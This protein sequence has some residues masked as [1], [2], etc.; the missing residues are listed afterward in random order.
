MLYQMLCVRNKSSNIS[1]CVCSLPKHRHKRWPERRIKWA[2]V[3]TYTQKR[4]GEISAGGCWI[5]NP[6]CRIAYS[7]KS[8]IVENYITNI[9]GSLHK[10]SCFACAKARQSASPPAQPL[11]QPYQHHHHHHCH[12]HRRHRR[13]L[14]R[15]RN[16]RHHVAPMVFTTNKNSHIFASLWHKKRILCRN[17]VGETGVWKRETESVYIP[18]TLLHTTHAR[19]ST[20]NFGYSPPPAIYT[21]I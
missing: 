21:W 17:G 20:S 18:H 3:A 2:G 5:E 19:F 8:K 1:L 15:H 12:C 10:V 4:R 13:Y 6:V 14:H 7:T 9:T 16:C 11:P